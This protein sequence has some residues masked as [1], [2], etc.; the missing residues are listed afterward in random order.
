MT[1]ATPFRHLK[2][3]TRI[4]FERI[5]MDGTISWEA[6]KIA[7]WTARM[8]PRSSLPVGYHP[9]RFNDGGILMVHRNCFRVVD[10]QP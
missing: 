10:N 7:Q 2:P 6:A 3:G 1:K 9:V 4:E 8:G 5:E